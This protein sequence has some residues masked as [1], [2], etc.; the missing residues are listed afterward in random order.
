[1]NGKIPSAWGT[2]HGL[3]L[4]ISRA[5]LQYSWLVHCIFDAQ[6]LDHF[7]ERHR[8]FHCWF[9]LTHYAKH[10]LAKFICRL[11]KKKIFLLNSLKENSGF[12]GVFL[13]IARGMSAFEKTI[14]EEI[15][16]QLFEWLI[17]LI[18]ALLRSCQVVFLSAKLDAC[19]H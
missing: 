19:G 4:Q 3:T 12:E 7:I 10:S 17:V 8:T 16:G 11:L 2:G 13:L 14:K 5:T 1:M 6:R 9:L 15:P 18:S